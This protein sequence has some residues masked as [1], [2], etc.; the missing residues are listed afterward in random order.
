LHEIRESDRAQGRSYAEPETH[1]ARCHNRAMDDAIDSELDALA[2]RALA[3]F[4][5]QR[6]LFAHLRFS[7]IEMAPASRLQG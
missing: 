1:C 5:G 3:R 2:A 4:G 7:P 6:Q